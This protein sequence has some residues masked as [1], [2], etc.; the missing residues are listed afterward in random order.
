MNDPI[1]IIY[2]YKNIHRKVQYAYYIFLGEYVSES[3]INI[4][5]KIKELN[6]F[7]TLIKLSS[8]EYKT[9]HKAY[10]DYWYEF[11][12]IKNHIVHTKDNIKSSNVKIKLLKDKHDDLWYRKHFID[13]KI[14]RRQLSFSYESSIIYDRQIYKKKQTDVKKIITFKTEMKG[15]EFD[16]DNIKLKT[17]NIEE[18]SIK[19][20]DT[21]DKIIEEIEEEI[22]DDFNMEEIT[23]MFSNID[24]EK[25]E[26]IKKTS[27]MISNILND[28]E[29]DTEK[30]NN[31]YD[32][33]DS[34]MNSIYDINFTEVYY[35]NYVYTEYIYKDDTIKTMK[36]KICSSIKLN[37]QFG[38]DQNLIPSRMYMWCSYEW[39]NVEDKVMIGQTWIYRNQFLKIDVEPTNNLKTYENL[40]G[41]LKYLRDNLDTKIKKEDDDNKIVYDYTNYMTA[42]E[43]YL[44]DIYN[45]IGRDYSINDENMR[46]LYDVYVNI[47]FPKITYNN[48]E[49]IINFVNGKKEIEQNIINNTYKNLI[50]EIKLENE[51]IKTV[52][53]SKTEKELY[54]KFFKDNYIIQSI[55]HVNLIH[56]KNI[57][58]TV[59]EKLNLYKIFDNFQV[60]E[61]YPFIQYYMP[62]VN[63][64]FKMFTKSNLDKNESVKKWFENSPYGIS[65]K[66][67]LDENKY[68]SINLHESQRIEYKITWKEVDKATMNNIV[69]SYTYVRDILNKINNEN[70][71]IHINIPNDD[72]FKYAFINTIQQ[73]TLPNNYTI[74]HNDLS[75][76]SRYFFPYIALVI[77]PKKRLSKVEKQDITS[78]YGTYL[79]YKRIS[80]YDNVSKMHMRILYFFRNYEFTEKELV[81]EISKQFNITAE[82]SAQ[83]IAKVKE[84]F[85]KSIGK[86][87]KVLKK[88]KSLPK[89]KPPGIGID[90]QGRDKDKYKI[91][92]TGARN[93]EQL[94]N[95]IDFVKILLY[96]YI[97]TYLYKKKDR[98]KMRNKLKEL[99]NIAKRKHKVIDIVYTEQEEKDIKVMAKLDKKRI[100][101]KPEKGQNQWSRMCQNSGDDK[102][103]RPF[104]YSDDQMNNM[105]KKGY[106]WNAK[107][108]YYEKIMKIKTK[109]KTE[110][111]TIRAVKLTSENGDNIYYTCDPNVNKEHSYIGFLSKGK[112]PNEMCMPC[113]FKKDQLNSSNKKKKNYYL[114]CVGHNK[115]GRNDNNTL[116]ELGDK[117]YILQD[118]NKIQEGR[119]IYLSKELDY[120]LNKISNRDKIIRNHYLIESKSGYFFKYTVR[121]ESYHFLAAINVIFDK[122]IENIIDIMIKTLQSDTKDKIFTYLNNGDIKTMFTTREK[123]I[124]YIKSGTYLGIDIVGELLAI[125]SVL[126]KNGIN[127]YVLQKNIIQIKKALEKTK[128]NET[129]LIEC[130]NKENMINNND[131]NRDNIILLK[132]EKYYQPIFMINKDEKVDKNIKLFKTFKLNNKDPTSAINILRSYNELNCNKSIFDIINKQLITAKLIISKIENNSKFKPVTQYIDNNNKCIYIET[133]SG[134]LIPVNISGVDYKYTNKSVHNINLPKILNFKA[135]LTLLEEFNLLDIDFKLIPYSVQY[136]EVKK[137][138]Y[139]IVSILFKNELNIPINPQYVKKTDLNKLNLKIEHKSLDDTI[140]TYIHKNE[141]IYDTRNERVKNNIY[142]N[143]SYQLFRLELSVFLQKNKSIKKQIINIVNSDANDKKHELKKL[144]FNTIDKNTYSLYLESQTGGNIQKIIKWIHKINKIP[145]LQDYVVSNVRESC[146]IYKSNNRCIQ[147]SHCKYNND[148][149]GLQLTQEMIIIFVNRIIEELVNNGLE[150]KELL[151]IENYYVSDVVDNTQYTNRLHQKIIKTSNITIDKILE[152]LF[153]KQNIPIIGKRFNNKNMK[154]TYEEVYPLQE[155]GK[156]YI[157]H[158]INNNDSNLRAYSNEYYWLINPLY[159]TQYRNI[160]YFSLIQTNLAYYFKALIIDWLINNSSEIK[161]DS[162]FKQYKFDDLL[163]LK[164]FIKK[165]RKSIINT[166]GLIEFY[167]LSKINIEYPIILYNQYNDIINIFHNGQVDTNKY[168]NYESSKN[169]IQIK[170]TYKHNRDIPSSISVIY[171]R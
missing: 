72:R 54:N 21:D 114:S 127:Y 105:Q 141:I 3:V 19:S 16:E 166:I 91:R 82:Y 161:N 23:Q 109:K 81:D 130:L 18:E 94:Y 149:C 57:S 83:E 36:N 106:V 153:G 125:P 88:F 2:K 157:Q 129:Y 14:Y 35:K 169:S 32:F 170:H 70:K 140:N 165:Y 62:D 144:L 112:N 65:I 41:N 71:T 7:D 164:Y 13:Y 69:E 136:T 53:H 142:E 132:D 118:T 48:F 29:W 111:V 76:F 12:F 110:D 103:R 10:G 24:I 43:V 74:N 128:Y 66:I 151:H 38:K 45:E 58:G 120:L 26:T 101:F 122:S 84:K 78:K 56:D 9:L 33:D 97:E 113:C 133:L 73:F 167:I 98:Q 52:E 159:D 59:S 124:N 51:I 67:K 89:M 119:F 163:I 95:I 171:N 60:S 150:Y 49:N 11:L 5:D 46:N 17:I 90:I 55:I 20:I 25:N 143:E 145:N 137:N 1:K 80:K 8:S 87:R 27:N 85:S 100:G 134:L 148:V 168:K 92:I 115:K 75:E 68:I 86:A 44:I 162:F 15:G 28:D 64:T 147:N 42:N 47:Y 131:E 39:E 107:T 158:I 93:K 4:L 121:N 138:E 40:R 30:T 135:T 6:F 37:E 96:L 160:G 152:D 156:I 123:Y 154:Q 31:L 61:E 104:L 117:L 146:S 63:L 108:K 77:E 116:D 99:T 126:T 34:N 22:E 102:Q 50:N 155:L 139:M 79:R